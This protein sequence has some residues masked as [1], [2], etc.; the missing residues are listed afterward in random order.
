MGERRVLV[1]GSQCDQLSKLSFLPGL[2]KD[3]YSVMTDP[4]I[5]DCSSALKSKSGLLLDPTVEEAHSG[6]EAS[7][8]AASED[9]ASLFIAF[10][11]HGELVGEDFYLL[12]KDATHPP[13]SHTSINPVQ[14]VHELYREHSFV[15]G[16]AMI[17]DTCHSG[18]GASLAATRWIEPD[19]GIR[20]FEILTSVGD[21]PAADGCFTRTLVSTLEDGLPE[22]PRDRIECRDMPEPIGT[23][24]CKQQYPNY[25]YWSNEPDPGLYLAH[26]RNLPGDFW[27]GTAVGYEIERLTVHYQPT[28]NLEAVV[29]EAAQSRCVAIVGQAGSGKST[30]A[31]ALVRS[32]ITEGK[33]PAGFANAIAFSSSE[34][35]PA[36]LAQTLFDQLKITRPDF[37]DA[38]QAYRESL[39]V[40]QYQQLEAS[41]RLLIGPLRLLQTGNLVTLVVDG[42]DQLGRSHEQTMLSVLET[43]AD[44]KEL[45]HVRLI[46]TCRPD[47]DIPATS[48]AMELADAAPE[49]LIAYLQTREVMEE[50]H[51]AIIERAEGNWLVASQLADITLQTPDFAIGDLPTGLVDIYDF[52]LSRAGA[53]DKGRWESELR[54][55]L[56]PLAASGTGS[57]LPLPLLCKASEVLGG[58]G[59]TAKVRDVLVDLRGLV[60]RLEPGTSNEHLS[61]FHPTFAEY[62]LDPENAYSVARSQAHR[63]VL[64]AIEAL[65][66][67]A[68]H[69]P[70]DPLHRYA[71]E[72]EAGHLWVLERYDEVMSALRGRASRLPK[73]NLTIWQSWLGPLQDK[74]GK[75]HP[76]V[77]GAR[78]YIADW[79]G[80]TG[81]ARKALELFKTL[82]PCHERVLGKDHTDVLTTRNNIA[83]WT[84]VMGNARKALELFETLLSDRERVLGKNHRHV[85][86]TRHNIA[87]WTGRAGNVRKALELIKALLPDQIKMLGEDHHHVLTSR[88][89]IAQWTG[90]MGDAREALRLFQALLPDRERVEGKDHPHVLATRHNIAAWTEQTGNVREALRLYK[91]LLPDRE[92]VLGKDHPSVLNTRNKFAVCTV[93]TEDVAEALRLFQ[94]LL[95]DM[96]RV[97]GKDDPRVLDARNAIETLRLR[98]K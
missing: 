96:E 97:L 95:P 91:A 74:F 41:E 50:Y 11:G 59:A 88:N 5:G 68:Q 12:P 36:L 25:L 37:R 17:L 56:A 84:G 18:G 67:H 64:D 38:E 9:Q 2:A 72:H 7:I 77:L 65:A 98:L 71:M 26:N 1:I 21:R 8:I 54:P 23:V 4:E 92:R 57:E 93:E 35:S 19:S 29:A 85:L 30:L 94:A 40:L 76:D 34:I 73:E 82:L 6:I 78:A 83:H 90:Q 58:P 79:T 43:L 52:Q 39:P 86:T 45:G 61:L 80:Q 62:L 27:A 20:R 32:G 28:P 48:Q 42:L 14:L 10:I 16:L 60:T 70:D 63:A 47:T 3:L 75:E 49:T 13:K 55:V 51:Q 81:D 89:N 44:D 69:E 33:V 31:A 22:L 24:C 15:D 46:V 87:T 53:S 66:P